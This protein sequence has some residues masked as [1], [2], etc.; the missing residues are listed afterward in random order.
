MKVKKRYDKLIDVFCKVQE[1]VDQS[2]ADSESHI[3]GTASYIRLHKNGRVVSVG[4]YVD[5]DGEVHIHM[6]G[7]PQREFCS[8]CG[9]WHANA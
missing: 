1:Q 8:Y 9:V 4:I 5:V 2:G 3:R 6:Q 7:E